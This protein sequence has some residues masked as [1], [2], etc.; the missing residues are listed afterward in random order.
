MTRLNCLIAVLSGTFAYVLLSMTAGQSGF[1]AY[2]QLEEQ[3]MEISKH[4]SDIMDINDELFLEYTALQKDPDIIAAYARKLDYIGP[5]ERLVKITGLK[6]AQTTLYDTGTVMRRKQISCLSE[7][8]CKASGFSVFL[9]ILTLLLILE[10]GKNDSK[11]MVIK[12]KK[13]VIQGIPV[14]D[15]SQV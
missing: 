12:N 2:R 14:Y 10:Y 6:P 4:T 5:G 1:W 9:L 3:K 15:I 8:I 7:K 11:K 13:E